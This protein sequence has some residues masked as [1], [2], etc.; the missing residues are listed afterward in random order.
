MPLRQ[1][2][3]AAENSLGLLSMYL[4]AGFSV[5]ADTPDGVIVQ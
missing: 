1:V 5:V 2:D 3:V 4:T